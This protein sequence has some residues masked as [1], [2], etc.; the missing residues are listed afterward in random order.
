MTRNG[1]LLVERLLS[2]PEYADYWAMKWADV[3]R[4]KADFPIKL[5][6]NAVQIYHQ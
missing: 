3:L 6:P 5:W 4:V 2:R 1:A